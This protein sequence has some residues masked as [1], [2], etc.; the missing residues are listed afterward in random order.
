M[1]YI[2]YNAEYMQYMIQYTYDIENLYIIAVYIHS[3]IVLEVTI[4]L[5]RAY[6]K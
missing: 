4:D 6:G 2:I 3:D 1:L 5:A